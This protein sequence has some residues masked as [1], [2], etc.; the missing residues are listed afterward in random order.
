METKNTLLNEEIFETKVSGAITLG[1]VSEVVFQSYDLGDG[2]LNNFQQLKRGLETTKFTFSVGASEYLLKIYNESTSRPPRFRLRNISGLERK[3]KETGVPLATTLRNKDGSSF[4]S[5]EKRIRPNKTDYAAVS[6]MEVFKGEA[7][8]DPSVEDIQKI[9]GYMAKIHS[10]KDYGVVP[11]MDSMSLLRLVEYFDREKYSNNVSIQKILSQI[12]PVVEEMRG[13]DLNNESAFPKTLVHGDL[14]SFN[15]L[16]SSEG[17]ICILDL[18]CL[19]H[20]QRV[21]DLAI[22]MANT[23]ADFTNIENTKEFFKIAIEATESNG[24]LTSAEEKSIPTLIKANY[25]MFVLKTAELLKDDPNDKEIQ[26]WHEHG[27]QGLRMME[28]ISL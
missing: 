15:I 8:L 22:F 18:G 14:H 10:M 2:N 7:L 11:A 12:E 6:V 13:L 23:C 4:V 16:K 28:Q 27:I 1:E 17:K 25:A 24:D 9:V 26:E 21:A 19:D 5:I 20:E 3:L